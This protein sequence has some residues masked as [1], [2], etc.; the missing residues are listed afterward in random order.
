MPN[1]ESAVS[2][3]LPEYTVTLGE[4]EARLGAFGQSVD[5]AQHPDGAEWYTAAERSFNDSSKPW[6]PRS[7]CDRS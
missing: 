6:A 5:F 3:A 2:S 4:L 1:H 7:P